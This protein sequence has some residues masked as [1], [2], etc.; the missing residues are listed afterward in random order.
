MKSLLLSY[1]S[2]VCKRRQ[3]DGR[4]YQFQR[5]LDVLSVSGES[6]TRKVANNGE[7]ALTLSCQLFNIRSLLKKPRVPGVQGCPDCATR[8]G[9][10]VSA[11]S[12]G[13][14]I[15]GVCAVGV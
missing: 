5:L 1:R 11:G 7:V 8:R 2:I 9:V 14:L 10:C 4:S 3:W 6:P 13:A 12:G 15:N